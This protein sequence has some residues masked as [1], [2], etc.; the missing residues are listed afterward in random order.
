V[1]QVT[2]PLSKETNILSAAVLCMTPLAVVAPL[3]PLLPYGLM[4][5]AIDAFNELSGPQ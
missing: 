3:R 2:V 5:V 1:L 4:L